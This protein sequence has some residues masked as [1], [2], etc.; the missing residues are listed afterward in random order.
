MTPARKELFL[1]PARTPALPDSSRFQTSWRRPGPPEH[2][3]AENSASWESTAIPA[4]RQGPREVGLHKQAPRPAFSKRS[5]ARPVPRRADAL[6]GVAETTVAPTLPGQDAGQVRHSPGAASSGPAPSE[7]RPRGSG[8]ARRA[9]QGHRR[10]WR[11]PESTA[12]LG[13]PAGQSCFS[14]DPRAPP[15]RLAAGSPARPAKGPLDGQQES[16]CESLKQRRQNKDENGWPCA[17]VC[18]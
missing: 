10:A 17:W 13:G 18:S 7:P 15:H 12:G 1:S 2:R 11:P 14:S 3:R 8:Q 6:A 5:L 9:A 4:Q 16:K